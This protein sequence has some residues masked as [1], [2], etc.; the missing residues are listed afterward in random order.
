MNYFARL[1][2]APLDLCAHCVGRGAQR[3]QAHKRGD[4]AP[5]VVESRQIYLVTY[6]LL[7]I[8]RVLHMFHRATMLQIGA[9]SRFIALL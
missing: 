2:S 6:A 5:T 1:T 3:I 8:D 4:D 9:R 7:Q